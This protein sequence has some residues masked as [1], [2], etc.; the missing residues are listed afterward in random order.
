MIYVADSQSTP[1]VNPG[2]KQGIRIGSV[3]DGKVTAF[4]TDP[5]TPNGG[6]AEGVGVDDA[7][8]VYGGW[9]D[10]MTLVKFAK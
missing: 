6:G 5:S 8:N 2:F 7:G 4:I 9:T 10:K 3:K 1:T